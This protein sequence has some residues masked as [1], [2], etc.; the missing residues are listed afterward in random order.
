MN[1]KTGNKTAYF[2]G[3]DILVETALLGHGLPSLDNEQIA[4][5]WPKL[6]HIKLVWLQKGKVRRGGIEEFLPNRRAGQN[7]KRAD[8]NHIK[9][10]MKAGENAFLTVS[11]L[12]ALNNDNSGRSLI[13]TAGLGGVRE[14]KISADLLAV[15]EGQSIVFATAFK[16]VLDYQQTFCYM[17]EN[18][19]HV[20]GWQ[21]SYSDGFLFKHAEKYSLK[22]IDEGMLAAELQQ[23]GHAIVLKSIPYEERFSNIEILKQARQTGIEAEKR[24]E[25]FHPAVNKALDQLTAGKSSELQL[26]ALL[27][28]LTAAGKLPGV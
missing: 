19:V 5:G 15:K 7:W 28:N 14:N 3:S 2:A 22:S 8:G 17:K 21:E 25:Q 16:D 18:G 27:D 20:L 24:G 26:N 23:F 13:V 12:L 11:A 1:L 4:A 6:D 9:A 10:M